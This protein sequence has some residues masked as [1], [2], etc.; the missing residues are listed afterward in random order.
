MHGTKTRPGDENARTNRSRICVTVGSAVLLCLPAQLPNVLHQPASGPL[1]LGSIAVRAGGLRWGL[2]LDEVLNQQ[3]VL[4]EET[5]PLPIGQLEM[6]LILP[7][8]T[9]QVKIV[10]DQMVAEL[11][12]LPVQTQNVDGRSGD[13]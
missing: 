1:R 13:K 11:L 12:G 2:D 6:D 5:D 4:S 7:L 3:A 10:I 8:P 9:P